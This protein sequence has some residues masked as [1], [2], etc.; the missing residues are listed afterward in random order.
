MEKL[1]NIHPGEVLKEEFLIPLK[2]SAYKLSKDINV[3][4]TRISE[5]INGRRRITADTALRLSKYFDNSPRFWLGLQ[6]DYDLED[7]I[8]NLKTE[9]DKIKSFN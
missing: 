8:N 5:I 4:Q 7:A 6:E 1:S 3:P 9:L 2:L